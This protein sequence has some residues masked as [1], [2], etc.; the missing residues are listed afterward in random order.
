MVVVVDV[1]VLVVVV[2]SSS[3]R[4]L[5]AV[6]GG[7][8]LGVGRTSPTTLTGTWYSGSV[9][10]ITIAVSGLT[11]VILPTRPAALTTGMPTLMPSSEPR[12][13]STR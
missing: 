10:S 3:G 13:I 6:G 4:P 2:T 11:F 12:S 5:G 9:I 7:T 8:L 1:V